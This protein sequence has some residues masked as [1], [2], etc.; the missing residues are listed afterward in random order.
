MPVRSSTR[1]LT[2]LVKAAVLAVLVVSISASIAPRAEGAQAS[3]SEVL[4][5]IS[6]T[7]IAETISTLE[8]FGTRE[9]H[10]PGAAMAAEYIHGEF[11]DMGIDVRYQSFELDSVNISN[12]VASIPGTSPDGG[13]YLIGAHYDSENREVDTY[14][15]ALTMPAPG[16]DDDAS[17]VAAVLEIAR[18]ISSSGIV[19]NHT[20]KFV[21]FV[22]E[23]MGYNKTGGLAGSSYFVQQEIAAE[24][25][26]AGSAI[27]DM[28]GYRVGTENVVSQIRN[29]GN[30][31]LPDAMVGAVDEH[32]LDLRIDQYTAAW[33]S[34][35]DHSSFWRVGYPS[36][37]AIEEM[38]PLEY[39]PFNPYYHSPGD[40]LSTL[41]M[42]QIVVVSQAVAG[43]LLDLAAEEADT[44]E[45]PTEAI[46][47]GAAAGVGAIAV[48]AYYIRYRRMGR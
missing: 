7:N 22:A 42:D 30:S 32:D 27:L 6:A 23:E 35:S 8:A 19:M 17:G 13:V 15:E 47:A 39:M 29:Y 28:I 43:G 44:G 3:F 40:T 46:V 37:L 38:E 10:T 33:L 11:E 9:F 25:E 34:Y 20:I 12:V 24:V 21:T 36:F 1:R 5:S 45:F 18:A 4:E 2:G 26:Y 16:A 14:E 48:S 41:S 31:D